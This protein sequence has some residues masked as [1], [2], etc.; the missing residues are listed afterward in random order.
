MG[1][2][3]NIIGDGG[4]RNPY[5][6][7]DRRR[8]SALDRKKGIANRSR[9]RYIKNGLYWGNSAISSG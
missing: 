3:R 1:S 9:R 8:L 7:K 4:E 6:K 5:Y 2:Q